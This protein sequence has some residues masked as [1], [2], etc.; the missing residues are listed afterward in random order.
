MFVHFFKAHNKGT[1]FLSHMNLLLEEIS[2]NCKKKATH[3]CH[4]VLKLIVTAK[5]LLHG[6]KQ[7]R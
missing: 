7:D 5:S 6:R 3:P 4:G 1:M 2:R